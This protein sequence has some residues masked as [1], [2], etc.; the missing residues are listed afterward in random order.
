MNLLLVLSAVTLVA[1]AVKGLNGF[2]YALVSTTMIASFLDPAKAVGL[3]IVP[4]MAA[5][6]GLVS[7][8][9]SAEIKRCM[10]NFRGFILAAASGTFLGTFMVGLI[11]GRLLSGFLGLL[12]VGFVLRSRLP[13]TPEL[14]TRPPVAGVFSGFLFGA[15]NIGIQI[16]AYL[17]SLS[18]D[19]KKFAG[20]LAIIMIGVSAVRILIAKHLGIYSGGNLRLSV[21]LVLPGLL[22]LYAGQK[23]RSRLPEGKIEAVSLALILLI[24]LRLLVKA[25]GVRM[26]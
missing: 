25:I 3:M 14:F 24:G 7:E 21:L 12:A 13:D 23:F 16:V 18:L 22:G 19:R 4:V 6:L 15:S 26:V 5:N 2:G 10:I 1:G 8:L 17:E 9:D 20:T 11:P